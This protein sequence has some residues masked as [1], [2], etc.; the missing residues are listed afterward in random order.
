MKRLIVSFVSQSFA[1]FLTNQE[2]TVPSFGAASDGKM[3][4]RF[5]FIALPSDG[6]T[7]LIE[8]RI[9]FRIACGE[10]QAEHADSEDDG[11]RGDQ[12]HGM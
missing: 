2:R 5:M 7:I 4:P 10:E 9:V 6:R 8:I 11:D 12:P 3:Q 1:S